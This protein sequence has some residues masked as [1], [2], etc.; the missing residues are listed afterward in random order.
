MDDENDDNQ[1]LAWMWAG[2][3]AIIVI[4]MLIGGAVLLGWVRIPTVW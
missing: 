3:A 2:G 1:G 4:L